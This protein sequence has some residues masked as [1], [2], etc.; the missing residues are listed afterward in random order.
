MVA[1]HPAT[2]DDLCELDIKANRWLIE[3]ELPTGRRTTTTNAA[4]AARA[5]KSFDR[6]PK[7]T[8]LRAS[9][10][11]QGAFES[12]VATHGE[13]L[14]AL[15]LWKCPRIED[16]TPLESLP[17]LELVA[18]YWNQRTARLWDLS[19]TRR[20]RGLDLSAFARLHDL[21]ELRRG[22]SLR[23]LRLGDAWDSK[24]H[25]AS[26]E[27]LAS[28]TGLLALDFSEV[29]I[30]DGRIE[31]LA[32]LRRLQSLAFAANQF[33]TR[34]VAWLRARLPES[35]R[36]RSLEPV[37]SGKEPQT[38]AEK[39]VWDTIVVGKRKPFLHSKRD[40]ERIRQYVDDFWTLVAEFRRSPRPSAD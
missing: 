7:A 30:D 6:Q 17:Q 29:R 12:L 40:A 39:I 5:R 31:P 32:K 1:K 22:R 26:L 2:L 33:T 20:L 10:L 3:I 13:R 15:H 36:S 34:Q 27:P 16:L 23:E 11:D 19:R 21:S 18:I 24:S 8:A 9:G 28:L 35:L 4:F 14:S 38:N 25:F 37:W